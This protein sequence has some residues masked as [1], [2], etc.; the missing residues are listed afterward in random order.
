MLLR[1]KEFL[2]TL[3]T[4][5]L[6][7]VSTLFDLELFSLFFLH[8]IPIV[9]CYFYDI[10]YIAHHFIL[11]SQTFRNSEIFFLIEKPAIKTE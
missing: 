5:N 3:F 7:M 4:T 11:S 6:F 10:E 8:L 9:S 2:T 1:E